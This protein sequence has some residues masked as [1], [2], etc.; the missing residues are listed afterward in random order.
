M[1]TLSL[2]SLSF[3]YENSDKI[4]LQQLN[5]AFAPGWTGLIGANG[6]GKSTLLRILAGELKPTAG[7]VIGKPGPIYLC[8]QETGSAPLEFE[9]FKAAHDNEAIHLKSS[10]SLHELGHVE[11]S[12]LSHGEQKRFQLAC[13]LWQKPTLLLVD[14]PTNHLDKKN[15]DFIIR[16]LK[17]FSGI[18]IVI[19][20]DRELLNALCHKCLFFVGDKIHAISGN[21]D[22]AKSQLESKFAY[23]QESQGII[24]QKARLLKGE[25]N[26]L[27]QLN[28]G[29]KKRLSK[30]GLSRKDHDAKG[31]IDGARLTGKDASFGQ[32]KLN[33]ATRI[34][35]LESELGDFHVAK[36]YS[37]SIFFNKETRKEKLLLH[38]QETSISLHE[39]CN[40][41]LTEDLVIQGNSKIGLIGLNGTG[42][43]SFI[44]FILAQNLLK[45]KNLY[46]LKQELASDSVKELAKQATISLSW[47]LSPLS[48]GKSNHFKS[49]RRSM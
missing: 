47:R 19:S 39:G 9:E 27:D 28:Q 10:L 49:R 1:S 41:S 14:E 30:S 43:S 44:R 2:K 20:H 23:F 36:D 46:Y 32:K 38:L 4:I 5:A 26:R 45:T 6:C 31:K 33:L 22:E 25:V 37:G 8:R 40:L 35:R 24:K 48:S 16:T 12:T 13:A 11:W 18:G 21:Y 34:A 3:S 29:S 7:E 17:Q 15:R 42:K